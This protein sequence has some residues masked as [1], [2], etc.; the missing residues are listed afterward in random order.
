MR[1]LRQLRRWWLRLFRPEIDEATKAW[2]EKELVGIRDEVRAL[3]R[4]RHH[5]G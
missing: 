1:M 4:L 5:G 3:Q 2:A